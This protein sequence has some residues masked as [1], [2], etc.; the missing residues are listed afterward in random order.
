VPVPKL[1]RWH[2]C[3]LPDDY[4]KKLRQDLAASDAVAESESHLEPAS[5]APLPDN[6]ECLPI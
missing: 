1:N 3:L 2:P 6:D 4:L 5:D